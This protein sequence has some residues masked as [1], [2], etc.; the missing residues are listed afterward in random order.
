MDGTLLPTHDRSVSASSKNY[1]Y[2]ANMQIVID[3]NTRLTV[4]ISR[5]TPG[6]RHDCR[7][8]RDSGIDRQCPGATVKAEGGYQ[9]NLDVIMPCS[10]PAGGSPLPSWKHDLEDRAYTRIE[11]ALAHMKT[12]T[13]LRNCRRTRRRVVRHLRYRSDAQPR[14]DSLAISDFTSK[15]RSPKQTSPVD[16]YGA[17]LSHRVSREISRNGA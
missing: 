17:T 14:H 7:A 10:S 9:G 13:A 3:T 16:H 11:H 1:Y 6:N 2:S 8:Y 4:A 15:P 12:W 5:P